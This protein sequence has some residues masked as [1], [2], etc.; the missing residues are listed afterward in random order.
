MM[1]NSC[2]LSIYHFYILSYLEYYFVQINVRLEQYPMNESLHHNYLFDAY[3][4]SRLH[5][6]TAC[7]HLQAILVLKHKR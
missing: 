1:D 5:V 3:F 4:Q 7:S 2:F 6:S